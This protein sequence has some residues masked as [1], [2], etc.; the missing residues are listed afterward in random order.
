MSSVTPPSSG[1]LRKTLHRGAVG[2]LALANGL[3][4]AIV[5]AGFLLI[6]FKN[7]MIP[8]WMTNFLIISVLSIFITKVIS[9]A[10]AYSILKSQDKNVPPWKAWLCT[11]KGKAFVAL[12]VALPLY[13]SMTFSAAAY[14]PLMLGA[15]WLVFLA[16]SIVNFK[17]S[18]DYAP[19][20]H[21]MLLSPNKRIFHLT[22]KEHLKLNNQ[23][24]EL[25]SGES[26]EEAVKQ[27]KR[28][29][30]QNVNKE[31]P[32]YKKV[33]MVVGMLVSLFAGFATA[34]LT[35]DFFPDCMNQLLGDSF[36]QALGPVGV[37]AVSALLSLAV[38]LINFYMSM[39]PFNWLVKGGAQKL[40]EKWK[41]FIDSE[42]DSAKKKWKLAALIVGNV[43]LIG[44]GV[45]LQ[46][47]ACRDGFAQLGGLLGIHNPIAQ[48]VWQGSLMVSTFASIFPFTVDTANQYF[49]ERVKQS[50]T[51]AEKDEK[52][53]AEQELDIPEH[54][55]GLFYAV[56]RNIVEGPYIGGSAVSCMVASQQLG[57]PAVSALIVG[58]TAYVP[59]GVANAQTGSDV[60]ADYTAEATV[61]EVVPPTMEL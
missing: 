7:N 30:F 39:V 33:L 23:K 16:S 12:C 18:V 19:E 11:Y 26:V 24:I 56:L 28:N 36:C 13:L 32:T 15:V 59:I 20:A 1:P 41:G 51:T 45:F 27:Y 57:V 53:N 14:H 43:G 9:S 5:T 4:S 6:L 52:A 29:D 58:G 37:I 2:L 49:I 42:E 17:M 25:Q 54:H 3:G 44:F 22:W 40:Y 60:R 61:A 34:Y 21:R 47:Y 46:A 38:G 8:L 31:I 10:S 55:E 35:Y 48:E 50:E